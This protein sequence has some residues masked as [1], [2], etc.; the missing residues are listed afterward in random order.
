MAVY[1]ARDIKTGTNGDLEI[2]ANGDL[3]VGDSVESHKHGLKFLIATDFNELGGNPT[4]GANIGSLIGDAD[5]TNVIKRVESLVME[6]IQ[7]Q[8]MMSLSDVDIKAIALSPS[9]VYLRII[10]SGQ[11]LDENGNLILNPSFTLRYAFPYKDGEL[12]EI[13]V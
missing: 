9:D 12:Q 4:F 11:Y 5:L 13:T 10:V 6:G 2:G 7:D 3:I 1:F 8:G